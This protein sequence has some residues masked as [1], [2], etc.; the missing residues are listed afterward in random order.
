MIT[1]TALAIG[2]H[3]G[4]YHFDRAAGYNE[5]NPGVYLRGES[6]TVGAYRNSERANSAYVAYRALAVGP[7][8]LHVGAVTGYKRAPVAPLAVA[9]FAVSKHARVVLIPPSPQGDKGGVHFA[10]EF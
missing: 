5:V 6:F 1:I 7:A 8:S 10:L 3:L 9:E 4:T 2:L